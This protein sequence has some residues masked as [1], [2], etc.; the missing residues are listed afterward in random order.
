V[1][2]I[3]RGTAVRQGL[4]LE[5]VE[6]AGSAVNFTRTEN[7]LDSET[8]RFQIEIPPGTQ[9]GMH[10]VRVRISGRGLSPQWVSG[11]Q[12]TGLG[13]QIG[14]QGEA[15]RPGEQGPRG[16]PGPQGGRGLS[17]EK[18]PPGDLRLPGERGPQGLHGAQGLQGEQGSPGVR[19]LHGEQGSPGAQGLQGEQ[20]LQGPSGKGP[21]FSWLLGLA[22]AAVTAFA[23][24]QRH[25]LWV[26]RQ[27]PLTR[28]RFTIASALTGKDLQIDVDERGAL[29][30]VT[31][32]MVPVTDEDVQAVGS[33]LV[34]Q[35]DLASENIAIQGSSTGP[36]EIDLGDL[37]PH[38]PVSRDIHVA[39][40]I[41][42]DGTGT[43]SSAKAGPYR[44]RAHV[45]YT[46]A[47]LIS[48]PAG[49]VIVNVAPD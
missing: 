4:R 27:P 25:L 33:R 32:T 14:S 1:D 22:L 43:R 2:L 26:G 38:K 8:I 30:K 15:G 34:L 16:Y 36:V 18:G 44:V 39:T 49:D 47:R 41:F 9:P 42:S 46:L 24:W 19:G 6:L 21:W 31:V 17:G 12:R 45:S 28:P 13:P 7:Q 11:S 5:Q 3:L 40:G 23:W 10:M 29:V 20:G 37:L 48:A 35:F